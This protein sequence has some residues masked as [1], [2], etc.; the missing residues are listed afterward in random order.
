M[1]NKFIFGVANAYLYD[2]ENNVIAQSKTLVDSSINAAIQNVD[3]RG[4]QGNPLLARYFHSPEASITLNDTQWNLNFL[5]K[6]VG[7]NVST[8]KN[9]YEEEVVTLGADGV[10]TVTG[11]P[12]AVTGTDVVGWCVNADGDE[13]KVD[14]TSKNFTPTGGA[15][16]DVVTIRYYML[17]AAA[18]TMTI[19]ANFIPAIARLVLEAQLFSSEAST[20]KIGTVLFEFP[21]V[22]LSGGFSVSLTADGVSSTPLEAMALAYT[23]AGSTEAVLGYVTERVTGTTWYSN[24]KALAIEGGDFGL[25]TG[26]TKQLVVY[27]IPSDGG[28]AF[29]VP[30]MSDLTFSSSTVGAATVNAAGL[31]TFVAAG[32]TTVKATIT[33]KASVDANVVVTCS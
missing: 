4:G 10:G 8:G 20:N 15:E 3:I 25:T 1:T 22:Q 2:E 11:T 33:E 28:A 27:A 5:A 31:V 30:V 17:D 12:L 18:R 7:G 21:R 16:G 6:V 26:Q 23:P 19:S 14:F 9:V 24:V 13:E 29:R 32:T